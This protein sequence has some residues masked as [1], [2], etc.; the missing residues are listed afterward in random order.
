MR[1]GHAGTSA[2][3]TRDVTGRLRGCRNVPTGSK[4]PWRSLWRPTSACAA[5]SRP[6]SSASRT[7]PSGSA[8]TRRPSSGGSPRAA[9]RTARTAWPSRRCS[10]V[11]EAYL[12]PEVLTSPVTQSASVAE[13]LELHPSRAAVPHARVAAAHR[14]DPR[15]AGRAD[16]RG[17]VPVRAARHLLACYARSPPQGVRCRFLIGDESSKAGSS[18][19]RSRRARPAGSRAASSST[20]ATSAT[21]PACP[22]VEVRT[23]STTLYNSLFRFDQDL[24]VNAHA[25]GEPA[26]HSPVLHLRRV[27][28]GRMWDH[29]MRSF[30]EPSGTRHRPKPDGAHRDRPCWSHGPRRL[31]ARPERTEGEQRGPVDHRRRARRRRAACCSST[32]STTTCGHCP[33]AAWTWASRSPTPRSARSPRRPA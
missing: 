30:D 33:A 6:P 11:D 10:S 4:R 8:W 22:G 9:S 24:M 25:Y 18:A 1:P 27:P 3:P 12:W 14:V 20:A 19:A 13:L 15:G 17:D 23:H 28:G 26:G 5:R 21:S 29:Y 32:R 7:W 2:P 31:L 16:L